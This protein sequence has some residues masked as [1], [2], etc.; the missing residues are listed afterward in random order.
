[1]P[2]W[3]GCRSR[4]VVK[5]DAGRLQ[6]LGE[7]AGGHAAIGSARA[8]FG[9]GDAC[10]SGAR[11]IVPCSEEVD[12]KEDLVFLQRSTER[13]AKLVLMENAFGN[14]CGVIVIAP[15]IRS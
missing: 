4:Q 10:G 5:L 15:Q 6:Q 2:R 13:R 1:M 3:V 11:R 7:V 14:W 9:G 12:E 8:H